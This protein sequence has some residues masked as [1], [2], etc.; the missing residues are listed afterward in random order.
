MLFCV[1]IIVTKVE[2]KIS[3]NEMLQ[4]VLIPI[5]SALWDIEM[6]LFT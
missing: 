5:H 1:H 4:F 3:D 2:K 6:S